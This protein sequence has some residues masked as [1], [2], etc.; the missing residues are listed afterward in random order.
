MAVFSPS[1]FANSPSPNIY[2]GKESPN[3][4]PF[5]KILGNN[6]TN[7]HSSN[8]SSFHKT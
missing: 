8:N 5:L 7:A 6:S 1:K 4:S 2:K 3:D